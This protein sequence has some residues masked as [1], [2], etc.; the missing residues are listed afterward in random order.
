MIE[1]FFKK[2]F[3]AIEKTKTTFNPD[4]QPSSYVEAFLREMNKNEEA[5]KANGNFYLFKIDN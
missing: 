2:W 3:Q 5:G 4:N 1:K